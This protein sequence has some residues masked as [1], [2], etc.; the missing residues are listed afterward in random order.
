MKHMRMALW[1]KVFIC[2][3]EMSYI[4]YSHNY[5][6]FIFEWSLLFRM[7]WLRHNGT[8]YGHR[9]LWCIHLEINC[10]SPSSY[11]AVTYSLISSLCQLAILETMR[12]TT[13]RSILNEINQCV[14]KSSVYNSFL[15]ICSKICTRIDL[16][17]SCYVSTTSSCELIWFTRIFKGNSSDT[18]GHLWLPQCQWICPCG[19]R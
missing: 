12:M 3:L 19:Y 13:S 18:G 16:A 7:V 17:L 6:S 4:I 10:H 14:T 8:S 5:T 2:N 15:E 11:E 1:K 9:S